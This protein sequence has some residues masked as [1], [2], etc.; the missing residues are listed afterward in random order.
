MKEQYKLLT[1]L[2]SLTNSLKEHELDE[3]ILYKGLDRVLHKNPM[4][5]QMS[6]NCIKQH[7]SMLPHT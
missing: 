3:R 4:G 1:N 7:F 2:M 6:Q 5:R